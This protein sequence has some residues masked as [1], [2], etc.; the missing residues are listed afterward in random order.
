M[1]VNLKNFVDAFQRKNTYDAA[2]NF[3]RTYGNCSLKAKQREDYLAGKISFRFAEM[4]DA[5][6]QTAREFVNAVH[7]SMRALN[8]LNELYSRETYRE[9]GEKRFITA[10]TENFE[11]Y[12]KVLECFESFGN[13][14]FFKNIQ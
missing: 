8:K 6:K 4:Q 14:A 11:D 10:R 9:S 7:E 2:M 5:D 1:L 13:N 12:L 3:A